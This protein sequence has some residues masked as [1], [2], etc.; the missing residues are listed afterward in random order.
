MINNKLE[1]LIK[2]CAQIGESPLFALSNLPKELEEELNK[3]IE[4][5]KKSDFEGD[6]EKYFHPF[7]PELGYIINEIS[8]ELEK[9]YI[10][11]FLDFE[12]YLDNFNNIFPQL[13]GKIEKIGDD[14][15]LLKIGDH[16]IPQRQWADFQ[17]NALFISRSLPGH[18]N[19]TLQLSDILFSLGKNPELSLK[20]RPDCFRFQPTKTA[21]CKVELADWY[22]KPF[23]IEWVKDLKTEEIAEH[24]PNRTGSLSDGHCT[25]ILWSPRKDQSIHL[26]IEEIPY[27]AENNLANAGDQIFTR[28]IHG[29]FNPSTEYFSHIDGAMHIYSCSE[30]KKRI[31]ENL[32]SYN[33]NYLKSKI[34][35][36]DGNINIK[37]LQGIVGSFYKWNWMATEYFQKN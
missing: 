5:I 29:I 21:S 28:F 3:I 11:T 22:G 23:N 30:Y 34:F 25:Q 1:N 24:G 6:T 27:K 19:G 33:K 35:R 12:F 2:H 10:N 14:Q 18:S 7:S 16:I 36:L 15:G 31:K 20:I 37:V 13:T 9:K 8:Q 4:E 17:G 26:S 32:K